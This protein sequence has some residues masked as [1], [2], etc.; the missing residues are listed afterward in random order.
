MLTPM[1]TL[2][3]QVAVLREPGGSIC[4]LGSGYNDANGEG[5]RATRLTDAF[6]LSEC[7][8]PAT[9]SGVYA[10]RHM[11]AGF[12][13]VELLVVIAVLA[14]LAALL[15][16]S[17]SR[18]RQL[19]DIT[20]CQ[21][22]LRQMGLA[23]QLYVN[24][25]GCYPSFNLSRRIPPEQWRLWPYALEPYINS[26]WPENN[27][28]A[29]NHAKPTSGTGLFACPG[30]NRISGIHSISP[31]GAMGS[32][33]YNKDGTQGLDS[34]AFR[35]SLGLGGNTLI[36]WDIGAQYDKPIG[37]ME[38]AAPADLIAIGDSVLEAWREENRMVVAGV[39][40]LG[41]GL[42]WKSSLKW[43]TYPSSG[44]ADP[45]RFVSMRHLRRWNI[46][47]CDGHVEGLKRDAL[48]DHTKD[49]LLRR[50]NRD[51]KPHRDLL[52]FY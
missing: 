38:V 15:L 11:R 32:Y 52:L 46:V 45:A 24:D 40:S 39:P 3:E 10:D 36:P 29:N 8:S 4:I 35:P 28:I 26:K 51:H 12:S 37:E 21:N 18:A 19:A 23:L 44:D 50:W 2:Q 49:E 41:P 43:G 6:T 22:N 9:L 25:F 20:V 30:Y 42:C 31:Y 33:G 14:I 1:S 5:K 7:G 16:P 17:L 34:E 48:F 13:L 47:F 27:Y